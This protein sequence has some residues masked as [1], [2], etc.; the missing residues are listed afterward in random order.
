MKGWVVEQYRNRIFGP[1]CLPKILSNSIN[2]FSMCSILLPTLH[3]FICSS[4]SLLFTTILSYTTTNPG[5]TFQVSTTPCLYKK[6]FA[7]HNYS[8]RLLLIWRLCCNFWHFHA[9][10]KILTV[11]AFHIRSPLSLWHSGGN[12]A[13]FPNLSF[14]LIPSNPCSLLVK[15]YCRLSKSYTFL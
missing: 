9:G 6:T 10:R 5:S 11:Y 2:P 4:K 14:K 1:W 12:S 15:V 3:I 8:K 7:L 13:K